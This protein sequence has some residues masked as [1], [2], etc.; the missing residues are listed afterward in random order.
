MEY[1]G[2]CAKSLAVF[3]K[4]LV[5]VPRW[6]FAFIATTIT[7]LI[8]PFSKRAKL[9]LVMPGGRFYFIIM[10]RKWFVVPG[11]QE[12]FQF[13][14]PRPF[15]S[16]I[17]V[18]RGDIVLEGGSALGEDTVR[19]AELVGDGKVIAVEPNPWNLVFLKYNTHYYE[20]IIIVDSALWDKEGI[21]Q[22][23]L[24]GTLGSSIVSDTKGVRCVAVS[25]TTIDDIITDFRLG[26]VDVIKLNIE[27]AEIEALK[28]ARKVLSMAREVL[29]AAHHIRDG[30]LTVFDVVKILSQYGFKVKVVHGIL[31]RYYVV[32]KK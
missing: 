17:L 26:K 24:Q 10:F 19:L 9:A 16:R 28:G 13:I 3:S 15:E 31:A 2:T 11:R 8:K 20:N 4:L 18:K 14:L 21:M 5:K 29:V 7:I 6:I 32:A 22:L 23:K 30:K 25:T 1:H 27:G 12:V